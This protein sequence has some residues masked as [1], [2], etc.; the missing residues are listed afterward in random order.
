MPYDIYHRGDSW[1]VRKRDDKKLIGTH[2]TR[3]EAV[4]QIQAIY[5]SEEAE[6]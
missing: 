5:A 6:K 2:A 3:D 1:E 4:K